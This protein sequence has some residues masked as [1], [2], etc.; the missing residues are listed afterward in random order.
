M[1]ATVGVDGDPLT[2]M[3]S[4]HHAMTEAL[5]ESDVAPVW[6]TN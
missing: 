2:A 4:E 6:R 1:L 3:E 5:A